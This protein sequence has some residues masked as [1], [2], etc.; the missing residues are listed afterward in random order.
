MRTVRYGS[1][2]EGLAAAG[3]SLQDEIPG[4]AR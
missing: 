3:L 2:E 1:L 4:A